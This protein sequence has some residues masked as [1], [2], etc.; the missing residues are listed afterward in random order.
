MLNIWFYL[1]LV[2]VISYGSVGF[3]INRFRF[4]DK[5]N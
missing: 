2:S 3:H 1:F 4:G 5:R